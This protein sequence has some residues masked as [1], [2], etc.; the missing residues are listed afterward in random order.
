MV[1]IPQTRNNPQ[2]LLKWSWAGSELLAVWIL[3]LDWQTIHC[4]SFVGLC[5]RRASEEHLTGQVQE[6]SLL[7]MPVMTL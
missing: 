7:G 3:Q 6:E 5:S 1:A 4:Q 2:K